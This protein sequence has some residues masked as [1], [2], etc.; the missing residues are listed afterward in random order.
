MMGEEK[1]VQYQPKGRR[2]PLPNKMEKREQVPG[3]KE[4]RGPQPAMME[5]KERIT[6]YHD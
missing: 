6:T 4:R 1:N 5:R 3:R 2:E